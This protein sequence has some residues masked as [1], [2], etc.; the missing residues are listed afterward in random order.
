MMTN[1]PGV[2]L[3]IQTADC[4]PVLVVDVKKRAVAAFH[5][6][7]RGTVARIAEQGIGEDAGGIWIAA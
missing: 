7:W 3:G 4:V 5:A 6:G 2:M 1:L